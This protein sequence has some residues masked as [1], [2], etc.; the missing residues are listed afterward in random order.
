MGVSVSLAA[1]LTRLTSFRPSASEN[2]PNTG[3]ETGVIRRCGVERH[4]A[5]P[6]MS[7]CWRLAYTSAT[8]P[9]RNN[10]GS[11]RWEHNYAAQLKTVAFTGAVVSLRHALA[12]TLF[13][14]QASSTSELGCSAKSCTRA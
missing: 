2:P 9:L 7:E 3:A 13:N 10:S 14:R 12:I 11:R 4:S 5:D 8:Q 1:W 6:R